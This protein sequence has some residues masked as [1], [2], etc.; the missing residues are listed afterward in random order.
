MGAAAT[1][2]G[3]LFSGAKS[4]GAA[5]RVIDL[6]INETEQALLDFIATYGGSARLAGAGLL[7][8]LRYGGAKRLNIIVELDDLANFAA[9][10]AQFPVP[11]A[12]ANGSILAFSAGGTEFTLENLPTQTFGERRAKLSHA[13][14]IAFA[15]DA[16]NY[17]P[18]TR[19][20]SDPFD[21]A[22]SRT[23][24]S[25]NRSFGAIDGLKVVL[26]G[27]VEAEQLGMSLGADFHRWE[28]RLLKL[29]ARDKDAAGIASIFLN[30]LATAAEFLPTETIQSFLRSSSVK[31]A[32]SKTLG[33]DTDI[34]IAAF[35]ARRATEPG[36]V[37]NAALWLSILLDAELRE[38]AATGVLTSTLENGTRF[39]ILRSHAALAQARE[40]VAS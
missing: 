6:P 39:E 35:D 5:S 21:A 30:Q 12:Y 15:H 19:R 26:R 2:A 38:E 29:M 8:K 34:A 11:G 16:L 28:T 3:F 10:L 1:V 17:D 9:A 18:A 32:I 4:L 33:L 27:Y 40:L 13:R 23:V 37:S 20:L 22:K 25:V 14:Y 24:R 7:E 36:S 31:S